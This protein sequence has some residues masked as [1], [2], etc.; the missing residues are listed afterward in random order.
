[1]SLAIHNSRILELL[2]ISLLKLKNHM[3]RHAWL[4]RA[5]MVGCKDCDVSPDIAT[6]ASAVQ[7]TPQGAQYSKGEV[8]FWVG[9]KNP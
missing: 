6:R 2:L 3:V 7:S 9:V 5:E 4:F 8:F 1:M